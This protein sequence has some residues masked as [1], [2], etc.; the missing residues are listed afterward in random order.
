ME[1]FTI[2]LVTTLAVLMNLAV[3]II[4]GTALVSL[5]ESWN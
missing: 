2:I 4:A 3:A 5:T 1:S